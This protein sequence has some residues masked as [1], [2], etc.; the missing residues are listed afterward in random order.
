L[1]HF[2]PEKLIA[3]RVQKVARWSVLLWECV[4]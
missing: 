1:L 2:L 3:V 4:A